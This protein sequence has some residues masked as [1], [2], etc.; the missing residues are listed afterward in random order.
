MDRR[1]VATRRRGVQNCE[2]YELWIHLAFCP[3]NYH[4]HKYHKL[5]VAKKVNDHSTREAS[6]LVLGD[7]KCRPNR[8]RIPG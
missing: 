4:F 1:L 8:E 3:I 6:V 5:S 7:R 2:V